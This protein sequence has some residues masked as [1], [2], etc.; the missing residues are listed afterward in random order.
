MARVV[1]EVDASR[2]PVTLVVVAFAVSLDSMT[3]RDR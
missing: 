3:Q 1:D 2:R